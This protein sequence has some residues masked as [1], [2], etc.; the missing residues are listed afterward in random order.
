MRAG[1]GAYSTAESRWS[2]MGPYY[3]MFPV[4]FA[5][6]VV[7]EYTTE[8]DTVLD[9]FAGRGTAVFSAASRGRTS[10]GIEINPVGWVY[11]QTK[12][13][14]ARQ[15]HV[16]TRLVEVDQTASRY[17][18]AARELPEF[19]RRCFAPGV[20][21]FLVAARDELDWR[22]SVV[23]R[24]TMAFILVYLH[25]KRGQALSNQMRQTKAMSP[26]YA[27]RWWAERK[28]TPPEID[29]VTFL[30]QRVAWR[31]AKGVP[32]STRGSRVYLADATR[33]LNRCGGLLKSYT[34]PAKLLF[35]SPPYFGVTNYHY[36]Q[37]LRLWVLGGRPDPAR[38][39]E[40]H[41]GKFEHP[42]AYRDL[43]NSVFTLSASMLAP[44]AV[45]YVRTDRRPE[46]YDVTREVLKS[47]FPH[48]RLR[49]RLRPF[50][51]PTQTHLFGDKSKKAGEVDLVLVPN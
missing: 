42:D 38:S 24:T 5:D 27:I 22:S 44:D 30:G 33:F 11:G 21:R 4:E 6:R 50:E 9:P 16:L 2:G 37:W 49:R 48:K 1:E 36:D 46:T 41:R 40:L 20:L 15:A 18:T 45:V 19:F 31:Y 28:L 23:D 10:I 34:S 14:P 35:T 29:A 7:D 32:D 51:R 26:Q 39:G 47:V 17:A 8:G 43:L 13:E 12:L 25:G 3:A